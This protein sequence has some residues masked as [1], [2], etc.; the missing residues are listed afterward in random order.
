[1]NQDAKDAEVESIKSG[2]LRQRELRRRDR[3]RGIK[4]LK[5]RVTAHENN[6]VDEVCAA[7]SMSRSEVAALLFYERAQSLGI[8]PCAERPKVRAVKFAKD[9]NTSTLLDELVAL[10]GKWPS[11]VMTQAL[12]NMRQQFD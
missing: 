3:A 10:T 11:A 8:K 6:M 2:T 12:T 5:V 7:M 4:L 1:M 9:S